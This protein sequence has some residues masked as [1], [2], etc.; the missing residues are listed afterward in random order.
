MTNNA[1]REH[2]RNIIAKTYEHEI[3]SLLKIV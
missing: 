1:H 3:K 2:K